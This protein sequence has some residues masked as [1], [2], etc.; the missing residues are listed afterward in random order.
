MEGA[1]ILESLHGGELP[2]RATQ[3]TVDFYVNNI[4]LFVVFLENSA[5][6]AN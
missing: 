6:E 1:W 3:S 2:S 5:A 4:W